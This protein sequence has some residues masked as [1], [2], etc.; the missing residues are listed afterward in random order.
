MGSVLPDFLPASRGPEGTY[1]PPLGPK[2]PLLPFTAKGPASHLDTW[3]ERQIGTG[4]GQG[5]HIAGDNDWLCL[6]KGLQVG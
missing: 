6:P 4:E 2:A 1:L 3:R 5:G